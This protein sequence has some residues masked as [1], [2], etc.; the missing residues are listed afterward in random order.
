VAFVNEYPDIYSPLLPNICQGTDGQNGTRTF[1]ELSLEVTC[2]KR[3]KGKEGLA[4]VSLGACGKKSALV[5]P[6]VRIMGVVAVN[7]T[8]AG[9]ALSGQISSLA[10]T[11]RRR[12][13]RVPLHWTL[14]LRFN[15]CMHALRTTT[16]DINRDG[17]YCLLDRPVRPGEQIDCDIVVPAHR[18]QDP[19]DVVYLRCRAQAVRVER[20]GP[21]TEFGVAC[22]IEDYCLIRRASPR[23]RLQ[24]S[25]NNAI[26]GTDG[27][28]VGEDAE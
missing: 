23:L 26:Y 3:V 18:S 22:R 19:D 5:F 17:F 15:G 13:P 6:D 25:R 21:G 7:G 9:A 27:R 28:G 10:G 20:V 24:E 1:K 11:E 12:N 14:Y 8:C 2:Y 4:Q 16:R